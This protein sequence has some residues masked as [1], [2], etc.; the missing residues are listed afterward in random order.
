MASQ[1]ASRITSHNLAAL[2]VDALVD[3]KLVARS[4]LDAAIA[5]AV[6]EIDVRKAMTDQSF[7]K[8]NSGKWSGTAG[9]AV[10][11]AGAALGLAI[12]V[13]AT[14]AGD[15][16]AASS[17]DANVPKPTTRS[18]STDRPDSRAG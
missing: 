8:I 14:S 12:A 11:L 1:P 16:V 3:A 17:E 6:V 5:V 9:V 7:G 13:T 15:A 18:I 4:D 10:A 2:I